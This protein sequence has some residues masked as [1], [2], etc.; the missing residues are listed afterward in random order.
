MRDEGHGASLSYELEPLKLPTDA[1]INL[2]VVV[3]E[4]VT[5]AFKYAY[6]GRRGEVR[7]RL[8]RL[9]DG[10]RRTAVEDD[11]VGRERRAGAREPASA[12]GSSRRW[13]G[14]WGRRSSMS[15]GARDRGAADRSRSSRRNYSPRNAMGETCASV[16]AAEVGALRGPRVSRCVSLG[17]SPHRALAQDGPPGITEPTVFPPFDPNAPACT[18]PPGLKKVLA[19]AQDNEREFMQGVGRGLAAAAK[20]RGL[21]YRV[22]L[23]NNDAAKMIEQV[24]ALRA[25]KVGAVV[26]APVDPLALAP[27]PAADDLVRRLCRH[28]RAAAGDVAA[29]RAAIS[30]RQGARRCRGRLHQGPARRQ[31]EASCC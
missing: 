23:A 12:P 5:N 25:A 3:T 6:P 15:T 16:Q 8:K 20:D 26:A 22:A 21:D 7:V 19:F 11:G 10:P 30:D 31:G 14:P 18:A 2:G 29:Q 17:A 4:W 13:R 1:S 24:Q 27:Q 28:R 9:R